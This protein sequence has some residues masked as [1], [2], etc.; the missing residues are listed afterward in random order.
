VRAYNRNPEPTV[1]LLENLMG[2]RR[3]EEGAW[4]LRGESRGGWI[5]LDAAPEEPGR[6]SAGTVHHVAWATTDAEQPSWLQALRD[7]NVH[8]TDIIDRHFFH[9]VYFREPGGVLFE[10]A[11][12]EPGFTVTGPVGEFGRRVILPPWLESSRDAIEARLTPLPDPR[13]DW[14]VKS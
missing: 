4:E 7:A 3:R 8:S 1:G 10:L 12:R 5:A 11:T 14:A 6:Q 2:A 9:S 13:A